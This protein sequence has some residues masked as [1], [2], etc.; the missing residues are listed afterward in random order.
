MGLIPLSKKYPIST[1][2]IIS[3]KNKFSEVIFH[4]ENHINILKPIVEKGKVYIDNLN[5][6]YKNK[7][8]SKALERLKK[9]F[10]YNSAIIYNRNYFSNLTFYTKTMLITIYNNIKYKFPHSFKD[11][12]FMGLLFLLLRGFIYFLCLKLALKYIYKNVKNF[13]RKQAFKVYGW[14]LIGLTFS[15]SDIVYEFPYDIIT[16]K[17]SRYKKLLGSV[18]V[19][20]E[21]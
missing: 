4:L 13:K 14:F 3:I 15:I 18:N 19:K 17:M 16:Y 8:K 2:K 6:I 20:S 5:Q 12:V 9:F 21:N 10:F 1:E 11:Y 7:I